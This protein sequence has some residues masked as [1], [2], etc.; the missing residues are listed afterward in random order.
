MEEKSFG[1]LFKNANIYSPNF[2][3]ANDILV[4][5]DIIVKIQKN[6]NIN[7]DFIKVIDIKGKNIIPGIID[8]HIHIIGGG[9]EG[10]YA[11]SVPEVK[12]SDLVKSGITTLVGLLGTDSVTK[13]I[14]S[15]VAKTK[16]IKHYGLNAYCLT[17][18]YDYPSPTLLNSVKEDIVFIEEIIG[19]K[20]ALSDHRSSHVTK[21][22]LLRLASQIRTA[23]LISNKKAYLKLHLGSETTSLKLVNEIIKET[24]IPIDI[25][26]PTHISRT[27]ELL[28]EAIDFAS[29][30]GIIDFTVKPTENFMKK[31]SN[32]LT[33][34]PILDNITFSSDAM[35][36][37]STYK[38]GELEKIG[39]SPTNAI[40]KTI[41]EIVKRKFLP[42]EKALTFATK[43]PAKALGLKFRGE[44]KTG[45][46]ADLLVIDKNFE[47][48]YMLA[49]GKLLIDNKNIL[50][51]GYYE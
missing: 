20:L 40:I 10:G 34:K 4:I 11:S 25:F 5:N 21:A 8:Q 1:Y 18:A 51:K 42:L 41:A 35:G 15:L 16:A 37:W 13:D 23:R 9:G 3:G 46:F 26:R 45:N 31:F 17:G 14:K 28:S 12:I 30:G 6:I 38:N 47:I 24:D 36:S 32:A 22:E 19:C 29:N 50:L 43:N 27:N 33:K 49:N 7:Y 48:N 44:I 2:L 39:H